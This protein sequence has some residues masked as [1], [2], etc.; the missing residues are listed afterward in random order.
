MIGRTMDEP[1]P[2]DFIPLA[3]AAALVHER[4]FPGHGGKE[5]KTLDMIAVA[6]SALVPLYQRDMSSGALRAVPQ[7]DIAAGRF[8]RGATTLEI[9]HRSPLRFLVVSREDAARAAETLSRDSVIAARVSQG[10]RPGP[11]AQ[12]M[13]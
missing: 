12:S 4:L 3:R 6:L 1:R 2:G 8:T 7:A 9:P 10:L 11:G 13:R 5:S